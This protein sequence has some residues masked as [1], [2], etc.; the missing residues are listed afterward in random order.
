VPI[1]TGV[2]PHVLGVP[3][4][5]HVTPVPVQLTPPFDAVHVTGVPQLSLTTPHLPA[6]VTLVGCG[7]QEHDPFWQV[8]GAVHGAQAVPQCIESIWVF[9]Q[10]PPH[11]V[12]PLVHTYPHVPFVQF[13][14]AFATAV[15]HGVQFAPQCV[16][17]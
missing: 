3:P 16:A 8:L 10:P 2:Q 9:Q 13:G 4:P 7:V 6:H 12:N 1:G 11:E 5:P 14:A 15:V 17:S